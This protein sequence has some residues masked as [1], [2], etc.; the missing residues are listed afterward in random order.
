M[1]TF[2]MDETNF[3]DGDRAGVRIVADTGLKVDFDE[4]A[5]D[6]DTLGMWH[7]P[8]RRDRPGGRVR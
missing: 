1:L 8:G 3:A 7:L 2:R 6:D 5:D 4:F